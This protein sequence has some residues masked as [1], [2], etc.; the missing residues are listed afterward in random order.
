VKNPGFT[1]VA[2]L[3]LVLGISANTAIFTVV[4]TV[5][6]K[7]LPYPNPERLMLTVRG[8]ASG[9]GI[10]IS[11]PNFTF[12]KRHSQV[13]EE[14]AAYDFVGPGLNL[15]GG[16][17]PEQIRGVHVS[18]EYFHLFGA[19]PALGRTFLPEE[20]MPRGGRVV[21]LSHG[22]WIRRFGGDPGIVGRT[23]TLSGEPTAVIGIISPDFQPNPPADAWIP[24]QADPNSTNDAHYLFGTALLKAGITRAQAEAQLKTVAQ[25]FRQAY[26]GDWNSDES[27]R[28]IPL[29]ES[30]V[31]DI[32]PALLILLGAVTFVLLIACANVAN[33]LLA[34][35]AGRSK[36]VAIRIAVGAGRLRLIRQLLTE[37]VLMGFT[38]L[39]SMLT[40]II[41]GL[42][43][44]L[45]LSKPDLNETL[46]E[47]IGRTTPG[48]RR[49]R[50]RGLLVV[51]EIALA[52][53]LLIGAALLIR[54][55]VSLRLVKPGF[56]PENVLTMKTSMSGSKYT[57]TAAVESFTVQV[58]RRI[59]SLPGVQFASPAVALPLE[60]GP[61]M[62][63]VVE[64]RPQSAPNSGGDVQWR[65]AGPHYFQAIGTPLL[66]GRFF[67]DG[68]SGKAARVAIINEAM[69]RQFWSGEDPIGQR[70]S[71]GKGAKEFEEPPR[72]IV[73]II[74]D[75][76]ETSLDQPATPTIFIPF[77]QV[78]DNLTVLM[79]QVL[80]TSW[81]IRTSVDPLSLAS[82]IQREVMTVDQLLPI[83]GV[84][85]MQQVVST[86]TARQ[87][88]NMLLLSVF[89]GIALLLA[90]IGIYGVMS[91]SVQQRTH[92]IGIRMALGADRGDMLRMVVGTGMRLTVLGVM[93]GIAGAFGLTRLLANLLFGV[94]ATDPTTFVGIALA[95]SL[96]ALL[97]CYIPARRATKID[98]I[99]ALRYE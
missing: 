98:P 99:I 87:N 66:R 18:R 85:S 73:G 5:L 69:A 72:Q 80:P 75:V 53:I 35:A 33:L 24:L 20:D 1:A 2:V 19:R 70:I 51:S 48:L 26:H 90:A 97:A 7:P 13:F 4:D 71:I 3:A 22:L 64:G 8:F 50:T 57:N 46:K 82:A 21:V 31:G 32:R 77:G 40:S 63:F 34:R 60:L 52:V 25:R 61:D 91:Y 29:Q 37:S 47:G 55:F 67:A 15:A 78:V 49:N 79:N 68:D 83:T 86:S 14:F 9:Y 36:E 30:M 65:L 62:P 12:W 74:G 92:E 76:R 94:R 95:L 96:V 16:D 28:L 27:I 11:I 44:A 23:I 54:T 84:R 58:L 43:P 42:V 17:K 38:L 6:L 88:F 10:S 39:I 56:N 81:V 41:F 45:Q 89:A 93:A 59:E